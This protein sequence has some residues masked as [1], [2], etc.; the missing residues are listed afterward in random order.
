MEAYAGEVKAMKEG[1]SP[2]RPDLELYSKRRTLDLYWQRRGADG[3]VCGH[4]HHPAIREMG[5]VTYV[6]A[7]DFVE[8]CSLVVDHFDGRFEVLRWKSPLRLATP[9]ED[10]VSAEDEQERAQ[11][12]AA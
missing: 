3:V 5:G 4:I 2:G 1:N 8:S 11:A 9:V 7:G 6:N 12:E 10:S